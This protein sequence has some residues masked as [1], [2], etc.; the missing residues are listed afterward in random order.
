MNFLHETKDDL[1]FAKD[2]FYKKDF[3]GASAIFLRI[4]RFYEA[5]V[6]AILL[7][8]Q[9]LAKKFFQRDKSDCFA[10]SWG[11]KALDLM[12]LKRSKNPT[13]LQIR[14]FYEI[15]VS[16]LIENSLFAYAENLIN[17][18]PF[19][20]QFNPEV[21]KFTSRV[22]YAHNYFDISLDFVNRVETMGFHD[23]EAFFI[24]AQIYFEKNEF[25]NSLAMI[26]KTLD[27]AK[28]YFPALELKKKIVL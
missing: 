8:E 13:Y 26:E 20:A 4:N 28:N 10:T 25:E 24:A 2:L 1:C 22:L 19:L 9:A 6:C 7:N 12:N 18:H 16:L 3:A 17:M 5:G 23:P 27:C 11:L 15:F 21:Y 14:A